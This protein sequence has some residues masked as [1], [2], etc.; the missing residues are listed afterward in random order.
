M[1]CFRIVT[2]DLQV[3]D[4]CM[5]DGTCTEEWKAIID[6]AT[7]TET[8]TCPEP[9]GDEFLVLAPMII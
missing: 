7:G 8:K 5:P 4:L 3:W 1:G 9:L 2:K 6:K